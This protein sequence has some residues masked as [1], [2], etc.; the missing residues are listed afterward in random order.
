MFKALEN[1]DDSDGT[2]GGCI[3]SAFGVLSQLTESGLDEPLRGEMF[4]WLLHHYE[5]KTMKGWSWYADLMKVAINLVKTKEEKKR[6]QTD[7]EQVK[8]N[9]KDWD[10]DYQAAQKLRL[11]LIERTEDESAAIRF[12]ETNLDN[13]DFRKTLI[14]KDTQLKKR[15]KELEKALSFSRLETE[16]RDLMITRAE[17]YFNIP[18]RKKSGAKQ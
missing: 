16:A 4:G 2:I 13:S 15:I 1:A 6:I 3:G 9:G 11:Q 18:I 5:A 10:W 7:L 17:E 8:P 14:E 12:M